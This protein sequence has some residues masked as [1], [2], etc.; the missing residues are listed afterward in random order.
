MRV[1]VFGLWHLGCVTAACLAEAGRQVMGLD[2]DASVI[3]NL[4]RGQ[5]PL[6]EPGLAELLQ[7]GIDGSTLRFSRD[8]EAALSEAEVLWVAFDTPVSDEDEADVAWVRTQLDEGA[9]HL[10]P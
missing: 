9:P 1:T 2:L 5:P 10:R 4:G 6:H 8:S 7:K 3:D